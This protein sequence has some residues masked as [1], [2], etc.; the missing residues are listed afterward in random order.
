MRLLGSGL[1]E[2]QKVARTLQRSD[3]H[4]TFHISS[5]HVHFRFAFGSGAHAGVG[6]E[7]AYETGPH[8]PDIAGPSNLVK[9]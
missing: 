2:V 9:T 7:A 1:N 4:A 3:V 8:P 5:V 6:D